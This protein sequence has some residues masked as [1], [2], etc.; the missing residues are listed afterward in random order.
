[1]LPGATEP[2]YVY[3]RRGRRGQP[4]FDLTAQGLPVRV[5]HAPLHQVP[6][7]LTGRFLTAHLLNAPDAR[8]VDP[9]LQTSETEYFKV[10][11]P[12]TV[13]NIQC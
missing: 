7:Q 10:D 11:G 8:N 6:A 1:M 2:G 4:L 13:P 5:F 3:D 12:S 9:R